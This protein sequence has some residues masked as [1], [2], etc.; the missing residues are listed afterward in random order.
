MRKALL[1][2]AP[3]V[4]LAVGMMTGPVPSAAALPDSGAVSATPTGESSL[5]HRKAPRDIVDLAKVAPSILHD[6]RYTTSH[7]FVGRPIDGYQESRC[8]LT[9]AAATRLAQ[10]QRDV[11]TKGYTLKVYDCYR[12]QR[13]VNH[14]VR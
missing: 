3:V 14:F 10:V 6:I 7:N 4:A 12:P 9:R 11:R 8:F 13:A 2:T 1:A 5:A